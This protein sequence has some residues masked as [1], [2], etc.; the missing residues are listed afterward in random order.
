MSETSRCPN[1]AWAFWHARVLGLS[2]NERLILFAIAERA[3]VNL[4]CAP[5]QDTLAEDTGI[6]PRSISKAVQ[7]LAARGNC[8]RIERHRDGWHYYLLR[9]AGAIGK[10]RKSSPLPW[11]FAD[12]AVATS[13]L[14]ELQVPDPLVTQP[15][16]QDLPASAPKNA[17]IADQDPSK[18]QIPLMMSPLVESP[19]DSSL[20]SGS[21]RE[22]GNVVVLSIDGVAEARAVWN[23]VCAPVGMP[24]CREM[25]EPRRRR[26]QRLLATRF[27]EPGSWRAFCDDIAASEFLSSGNFGID[28]VMKPANLVKIVEGNY[29]RNRG[30]GLRQ[31]GVTQMQRRLNLRPMAVNLDPEPDDGQRRIAP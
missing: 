11:H 3:D 2:R 17:E 31:S 30:D 4:H 21:A 5:T 12:E 7:D 10:P 18:L 23:E 13:D 9:P 8:I 28:W 25:P 26:L 14:Q 27:A 24:A 1:C 20:R 15:E 19:K 29:R 16:P 6:S 22:G